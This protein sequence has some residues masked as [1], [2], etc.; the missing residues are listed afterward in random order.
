MTEAGKQTIGFVGLGIMGRPMS[1][2]LN[3]AGYPL[4]VYDIMPAGVKELVEAGAKSAPTSAEAAAAADVVI[5]MVPDSPDV[6]KAYLGAN[7][8]LEGAK[9][10]TML[11]DM[12]TISPVMAMK[13]AKAA[14]AKGCPMLDAPVSG[15][16]VGAKEGHASPS[17]WAATSGGLRGGAAHS[18]R[19]WASPPTAAPAARARWSRPA[20]RSRWP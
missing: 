6:E 4:V 5:T 2:H 12:T 13:V 17:W 9:P 20:T 14:A 1:Q 18:S 8:I 11:V 15:G 16:E 10:G 19:S 3:K 7:G